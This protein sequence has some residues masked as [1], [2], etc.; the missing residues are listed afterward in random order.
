VADV[1]TAYTIASSGGTVIMNNGTLGDST[2]KYWLTQGPRGLDGADL[3]VPTDPVPFGSGAIV[4]SSWEFGMRAGFEGVIL[5]ES[6]KLESLCQTIRNDMINDLRNCL[7]G[8]LAPNSAT[9]SW[10]ETGIGNRSLTM[11]Y[12]VPL[13]TQYIENYM[14]MSFTFGLLS[15]AA[16]F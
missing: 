3:R 12:E 1:V 10:A 16:S 5:I 2:D 8:A 14:L 11:Y 9:V 6:T 7:R 15:E 13:D 4:H